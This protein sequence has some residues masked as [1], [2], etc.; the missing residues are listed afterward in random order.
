METL[1]DDVQQN[2]VFEDNSQYLNNSAVSFI[3]NNIIFSDTIKL[4]FVALLHKPR[5]SN[6]S[7]YVQR[8]KIG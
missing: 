7:F 1:S 4:K 2:N 3:K 8:H 6:G 5:C